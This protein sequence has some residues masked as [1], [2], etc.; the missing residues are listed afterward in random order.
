MSGLWLNLI[1]NSFLLLLLSYE[2]ILSRLIKH[3]DSDHPD[4]SLLQEANRLVHNI[5]MHLNCKEREA[6]ENGQREATL[7]ELEVVIE[8]ITDLVSPDRTF[9][10]F[11]LVSMF[12]G[13]TTRKERGLFL[14]SDVLVIASVKKRTGTI[15]RPTT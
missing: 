9:L 10:L 5:L 12:S 8:G 1:R 13:Q 3:T 11:D 7:R 14:F 4:Q 2:L 15:K 6:L